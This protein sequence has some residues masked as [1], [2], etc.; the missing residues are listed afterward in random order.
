MIRPAEP[1]DVPALHDLVVELAIYEREP[2]AVAATPAD[3]ERVLFGDDPSVYG[4][5]AEVDG[6]VVGLALWF[7]TYS[8]WTGQNGVWLE[9]LFVLEEYRGRGL[10]R[11]LLVRLAGIAVERGYTRFEWTVLDWNTPS[12]DFYR[13]MGAVGMDEWTTQRLA[14]D[15]L[16]RVA[17]LPLRN[18]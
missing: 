2:D 17:A 10:G 8:T 18:R 16:A 1:R 7:L 11:D 4:L 9:D 14:G 12:I 15:A 5:V 13:A 6:R 3:L